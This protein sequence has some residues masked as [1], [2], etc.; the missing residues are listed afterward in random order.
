MPQPSLMPQPGEVAPDVQG[1]TQTGETLRLGDLRG[2]PVA[3]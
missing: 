3:L 2:R 1:T